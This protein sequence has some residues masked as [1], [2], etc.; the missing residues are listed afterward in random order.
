MADQKLHQDILNLQVK[1]RHIKMWLLHKRGLSRREISDLLGGTNPGAVGNEIK[2][3]EA[4]KVRQRAAEAMMD[5]KVGIAMVEET[6]KKAKKETKVASTASNVIKVKFVET[7]NDGG[8][9]PSTRKFSSVIIANG[10]KVGEYE[11]DSEGYST[12][13]RSRILNA[14]RS[15]FRVRWDADGLSN[16]IGKK[17]TA[18]SSMSSSRGDITHIRLS[19]PMTAKKVSEILVDLRDR[20]KDSPPPPPASDEDFASANQLGRGAR[21]AGTG[22]KLNPANANTPE[23]GGLLVGVKH[24][25][26]GKGIEVETPEGAIKAEGGEILLNAKTSE[27]LCEQLSAESQKDGGVAFP[28]DKSDAVQGP[29]AGKGGMAGAGDKINETNFKITTDEINDILS[30]KIKVR[31]GD[32]IQA[33]KALVGGSSGTQKS[34]QSEKPKRKEE[35]RI[36]ESGALLPSMFERSDAVFIDSGAEQSVYLKGNI[37]VK[38]NTG[39]FYNTWEDY[40]N[41]LLLHNYFFSDTAY[42]FHGF[43]DVDGDINAIVSQPF[44]DTENKVNEDELFEFLKNKGFENTSGHDFEQPETGLILEDL[45]DENVIEKDG[46]LFFIDTVFFLPKSMSGSGTQIPVA[47][48]T[49]PD[50]R[51]HH[52][53]ESIRKNYPDIWSAGGNEFGN[54]AY[55]NLS[56]VL[57]RGYWLKDEEDMYKRWRSFIARHQHDKLLAGVV[58]NLKWLNFP[59]IGESAVKEVIDEAIAKGMKGDGARSSSWYEVYKQ[60]YGNRFTPDNSWK[61]EEVLRWEKTKNKPY[62]T[63][64][65]DEV[66]SERDFATG[67]RRTELNRHSIAEWGMVL[68]DLK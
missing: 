50:G 42:Q 43:E 5:T 40:L 67:D 27:R 11:K 20:M 31:H 1:F 52:Y 48:W 18:T 12:D 9:K 28:C 44:V 17:V 13:P 23:G 29:M 16:L 51:I 68:E 2:K 46:L 22:T 10:I 45:H 19:K 8:Y 54:Q 7:W 14:V 66:I 21:L 53:A 38:E 64:T 63:L 32:S 56:R 35:S 55:E 24:T 61:D 6:L 30:G 3:Y 49:M 36:R 26:Q 37:V 33:A 15:I 25:P 47:Q 39:V 65:K 58:A 57:E 59:N 62:Y 4:D 41:S 34:P 60:N